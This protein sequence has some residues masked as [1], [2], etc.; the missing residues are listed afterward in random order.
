MI[1]ERKIKLPVPCAILAEM[2]LR[3]DTFHIPIG[4]GLGKQDSHRLACL[5]AGRGNAGA[6]ARNHIRSPGSVGL[7]HLFKPGGY[8][9]V[10]RTA[11]TR[12]QQ[13]N[14]LMC[15]IVEVNRQTVRVVS[16]QGD[17]RHIGHDSVDIVIGARK[18]NTCAAL[19]HGNLFDVACMRLFCNSQRVIAHA[20]RRGN[21]AIIFSHM[22][23]V[24]A[25]VK[26][27]IHGSEIA[28]TDA[29]LP[30]R[31][32]VSKFRVGS[33]RRKIKIA[34]FSRFGYL[35][36]M[37]GLKLPGGKL[38]VC[39]AIHSFLLL[40]MYTSKRRASTVNYI[41]VSRNASLSQINSSPS[42]P[43]ASKRTGVFSD[44]CCR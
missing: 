7:S 30:C 29:A 31:K 6:Y 38:I 23:R 17:A 43:T 33:K 20:Y 13:R 18:T 1:C 22:L 24:V 15:G 11:P 12:V 41:L 5:V 19:G 14:R 10:D 44:K 26:R 21:A 27:K 39:H 2:R 28:L 25:A 36:L 40:S 3:K 35:H 42:M 8:N 37:P 4:E 16:N 9:V 32:T 34:E